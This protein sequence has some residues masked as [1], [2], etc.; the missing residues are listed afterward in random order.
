MKFLKLFSI[1]IH[2]NIERGKNFCRASV[3][4]LFVPEA[5]RRASSDERLKEIYLRATFAGG[6]G[7]SP[8]N[9]SGEDILADSVP[10][11]AVVVTVSTVQKARINSCLQKDKKYG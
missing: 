4:D 10:C 11:P 1:F 9:S 6:Y 5:N 3:C 7:C 2:F 8:E